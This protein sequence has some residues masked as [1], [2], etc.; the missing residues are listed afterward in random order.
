[1]ARNESTR[2]LKQFPVRHVVK[3]LL[4]AGTVSLAVLACMQSMLWV[5]TTLRTR[6]LATVALASMSAMVAAQ[7]PSGG[8]PIQ[9]TV[10]AQVAKTADAFTRAMLAGD[11]RG[12]A[13]TFTVDGYEMPP[14]HPA[15]NGRAAIQQ[16]YEAFFKGPVKMTAFASRPS[17]QRS[18][19]TS[20]ITLGPPH[21]ACC[22]LTERPSPMWPSTSRFSNAYKASGSSRT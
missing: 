10:N 12:V 8:A 9:P 3:A 19:A 2:E 18:R 4:A 14:H 16:R 1:M 15:V 21:S 11:A 17:N 7:A 22:C 20:R 13:A 5:F 6:M